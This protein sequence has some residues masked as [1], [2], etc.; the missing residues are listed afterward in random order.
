[1]L[2]PFQNPVPETEPGTGTEM[3]YGSGSGSAKAKF[4]FRFRPV[5][6]HC[7]CCRFNNPYN[8]EKIN[9][10]FNGCIIM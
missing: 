7:S 8:S 10:V 2:D 4:A 9:L 1:M 5:P 3:R 6:Q